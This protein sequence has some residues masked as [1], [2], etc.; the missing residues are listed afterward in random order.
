LNKIS[1][2]IG[3]VCKIILPINEEFFLGNYNS[4]IGI[5][6]LGSL[7]LLKSLKNSDI[8][9]NVGIIGRLLT[10]NKG[11]DEIIHYVNKNKKIKTI[12]ICGK[13]VWG[14]RAGHS[15]FKLYENGMDKNG[16]IINSSSPNP[17][18]TVSKSQVDYFRNEITLVNMINEINISKIKQKII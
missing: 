10:E 4:K 14:H 7:N 1:K 15:L 5:C 17:V 16:R 11:I 3:E 2:V 12:I 6:T 8:L 13:E 18:L 9:D